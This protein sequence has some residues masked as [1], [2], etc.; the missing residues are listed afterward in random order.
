MKNEKTKKQYF[1]KYLPILI[2]VGGLFLYHQWD[3]ARTKIE[4]YELRQESQIDNQLR[5]LQ[6]VFYSIEETLNTY[7][8]PIEDEKRIYYQDA[9]DNDIQR[10]HHLGNT[11]QHLNEFTDFLMINENYFSR[12]EKVLKGL[13]G[14]QYT[15]TEKHIAI[16][17]LSDSRRELYSL[18][19][20]REFSVEDKAD[21]EEVLN[22]LDEFI[23]RLAVLERY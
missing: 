1:E 12:I 7:E 23:D 6:S 17:A 13:K 20:I 2:V 10:L 22:L 18:M 14:F 11:I 16:Q 3:E 8:F 21:R 9:L 4:V 5:E 15:E 19:D